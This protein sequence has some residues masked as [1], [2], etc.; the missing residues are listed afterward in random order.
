LS[1]ARDIVD[2]VFFPD[3]DVHAIPVLDRGFSPN[4][5]LDEADQLAEFEAPDSIARDHDGRFYLSSGA[6]V[7][8]CENE[9][10]RAR[11]VFATIDTPVG[12]LAW[13]PDGLLVGVGGHG[14]RL[15]EANGKIAAALREVGS[16]PVSCPTAMTVARDG[17]IFI[18]DGSRHNG[19]DQWLEDLMQNRAPSGRLIACGRGLRDAQVIC[20]GLS[21]P[22]GVA[23]AHNENEVLVAE[24]WPHRL[25]AIS[26]RGGRIRRVVSN[27]AGYPGRIA[28]ASNGH[29]WLAFFALRTQLTEFVL[30]EHAFRRRMMERVP[31]ELW[32]GPTL[33]GRF[34]YREPTQIG[35]IKKL[36]IQK[37]WA[38]ARSYGL[39]ARLDDTGYAL[40]SLHSRASGQVHGITCTIEHDGKLVVVSKGHGKIAA[41][42]LRREARPC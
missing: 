19:P 26:R 12:A 29:Y 27:F 17:T 14:V 3:R 25:S 1:L 20:D 31:P 37:P 13:S 23:V 39:V 18:A 15:L 38:P 7:F 35:R 5:R 28:R 32:I 22:A 33:G 36:G 30:R 2:R 9:Q 11:K 42:P 41:A 16:L 34:N 10:F 21:W 40:E 4:R 6:T 24:A 8:V